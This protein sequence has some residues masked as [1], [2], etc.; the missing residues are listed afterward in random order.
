MSRK[1]L[2]M[3]AKITPTGTVITCTDKETFKRYYCRL[4]KDCDRLSRSVYTFREL[5]IVNNFKALSF[6]VFHLPE[7]RNY[8]IETFSKLCGLKSVIQFTV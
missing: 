1:L 4:A 2:T 7:R 6:N 5:T 3:S 8:A